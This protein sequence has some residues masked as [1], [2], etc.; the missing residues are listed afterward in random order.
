MSKERELLKK[1]LATEWLNNELSYEVEE[2]LTQPE[3]ANAHLISVAPELLEAL[4]NWIN[5]LDV[6][7]EWMKCR[8]EARIAI[9]KAHGIRGGE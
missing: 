7:S 8:D 3:V 4:K 1:I 2:L 6:P 9:A 5:A